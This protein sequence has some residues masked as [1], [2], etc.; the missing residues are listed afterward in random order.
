MFSG[1][2]CA[3]AAELT[4][5]YQRRNSETTAEHRRPKRSARRLASRSMSLNSFS[6]GCEKPPAFHS[7]QNGE[8]TRN[9]QG[10]TAENFDLG[11]DPPHFAERFAIGPRL[12]R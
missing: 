9:I 4:A 12:L 8:Q 5:R 6:R 7:H 1:F 11:W 3:K 2:G 10:S